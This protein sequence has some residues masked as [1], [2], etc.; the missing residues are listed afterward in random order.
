MKLNDGNFE[1]ALVK[2]PKNAGD[3]LE[4]LRSVSTGE[5]DDKHIKIYRTKKVSFHF[6]Q[7]VPWTLDGEFGGSYKDVEI[8]VVPEAVSI[9]T[10]KKRS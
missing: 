4:I 5:L 10:E 2:A 1:V 7:E 9:Y 8:R 3:L 6:E